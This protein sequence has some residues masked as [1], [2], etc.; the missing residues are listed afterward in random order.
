MVFDVQRLETN[1]EEFLLVPWK[2]QTN[3]LWNYG[4]GNDDKMFK[5]IFEY[6]TG[7]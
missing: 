5:E 1:L 7:V 4:A 3:I 2:V 6:V